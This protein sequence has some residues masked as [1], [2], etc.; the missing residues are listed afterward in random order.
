MNRAPEEDQ[1][2]VRAIWNGAVIAE[3]DETIVIERNHY[4]PPEA[5]R[6]EYLSPTETTS[7]CPWKGEAHYFTISVNGGTNIDAAWTYPLPHPAAQ[8]IAGYIAFWK[9]VII[10][11]S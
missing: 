2:M 8:E 6:M 3:S 9:G 5:V 7:I 10:E 1:T 11:E 4:F